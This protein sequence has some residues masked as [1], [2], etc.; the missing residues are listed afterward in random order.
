MGSQKAGLKIGR[1]AVEQAANGNA[2]GVGADGGSGAAVGFHPIK[3][4]DFGFALFHNA[5]QNPIGRRNPF[6]M[7]IKIAGSDAGF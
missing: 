7:C 4:S 6:Q 2:R 1:A 5:L 3:Q